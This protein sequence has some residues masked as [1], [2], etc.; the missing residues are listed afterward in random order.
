MAEHH[1]HE[2]DLKGKN[3]II[4]IIITVAQIIAGIISGSLSLLSD[5]MHNFSDVLALVV[6]KIAN[7]ISH[8]IPDYEKTFGYK[9]SK[10]IA[11]LFNSSILVAIG[12]YLVFE[13]IVRFFNPR[14]VESDLV[15]YGDTKYSIKFCKRYFT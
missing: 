15:I 2:H 14:V 6:T 13:A 9:R 5:A 3:L 1:H 11:A 8:R 4:T 10:V 7:T 12:L